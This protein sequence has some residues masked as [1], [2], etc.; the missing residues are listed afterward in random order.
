MLGKNS[1]F[2]N[3]IFLSKFIPTFMIA[4]SIFLTLLMDY[5][6]RIMNSMNI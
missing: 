6:G 4:I 3:P 1:R 2:K 5:I